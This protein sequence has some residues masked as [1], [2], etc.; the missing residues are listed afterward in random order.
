MLNCMEKGERACAMV[1][2]EKLENKITRAF[3]SRLLSNFLMRLCSSDLCV[4][5][6]DQ[7]VQ[8]PRE[9]TFLFLPHTYHM[10]LAAKG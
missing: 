6:T 1:K 10:V 7:R 9:Q 8:S 2:P 4:K 3:I 5:E